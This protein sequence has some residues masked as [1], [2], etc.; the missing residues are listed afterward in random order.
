LFVLYAENW[1]GKRQLGNPRHCWQDNIKTDRKE[2]GWKGMGWID[3]TED[4]N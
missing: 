2:I 3:L 1:D 4:K